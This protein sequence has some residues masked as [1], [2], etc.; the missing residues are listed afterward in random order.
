MVLTTIQRGGKHSC[1][2]IEHSSWEARMLGACCMLK[3]PHLPPLAVSQCQSH[4]AEAKNWTEGS[5]CSQWH[6]SQAGASSRLLHHFPWLT[7]RH[8][9]WLPEL[10]PLAFFFRS[11][12]PILPFPP[13]IL[14]FPSLASLILSSFSLTVLPAAAAVKVFLHTSKLVYIQTPLHSKSSENSVYS[15]YVE[16]NMSYPAAQRNHIMGTS[17]VKG[18]RHMVWIFFSRRRNKI[19]IILL[20]I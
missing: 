13:V 17:T 16:E 20:S 5:S 6:S 7:A 1:V 3:A 19:F 9:A 12:F 4:G 8:T 10:L 18:Q 2:P 11:S 14:K 15:G